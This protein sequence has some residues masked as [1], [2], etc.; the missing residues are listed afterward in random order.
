MP[1]VPALRFLEAA[2]TTTRTAD[3]RSQGNGGGGGGRGS[4]ATF[5][6]PQNPPTTKQPPKPPSSGDIGLR[7]S[8]PR[9]ARPARLLTRQNYRPCAA[10]PPQP[11]TARQRT[12][13]GPAALPRL[14]ALPYPA[15]VPDWLPRLQRWRE[16][17]MIGRRPRQSRRRRRRQPRPPPAP[18]FRL[19]P[20]RAREKPDL[21]KVN[22]AFGEAKPCPSP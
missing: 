3:I 10:A 7:R 8:P 1:P 19:R 9:A 18:P 5:P 2:N 21:E 22:T 13:A 17:E 20:L 6:P 12:S 15:A 4:P 11:V 16:G 14:P